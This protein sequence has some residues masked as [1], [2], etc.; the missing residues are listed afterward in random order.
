M[1]QSPRRTVKSWI[2]GAK[3]ETESSG[4]YLLP[5]LVEHFKNSTILISSHR[6][7]EEY[8]VIKLL[9]DDQRCTNECFASNFPSLYA[10]QRNKA[11]IHHKEAQ[12]EAIICYRKM[13]FFLCVLRKNYTSYTISTRFVWIRTRESV[14]SKYLGWPNCH[15]S[16]NTSW[17][18][19]IAY[20][21]FEWLTFIRIPEISRAGQAYG[22]RIGRVPRLQLLYYALVI[23]PRT[24]STLFLVP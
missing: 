12:G 3:W 16:S 20:G 17:D 13:F 6:F 15:N 1:W 22:I 23:S 9:L 5:S 2:L 19:R 21:S 7:L 8:K 24:R 4:L 18:F 10:E 11:L 14:V